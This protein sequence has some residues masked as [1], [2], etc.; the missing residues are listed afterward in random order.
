VRVGDHALQVVVGPTA[1]QVAGQMRDRL[2]HPAPSSGRRD[3]LVA[4][5]REALGGAVNV[6][7]IESCPG[8]LLVAVNDES[9]IDEAALRKLGVRAIAR[10]SPG[11]LHLLHPDA[12]F[13][14]T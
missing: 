12:E 9:R 14:G 11:V 2:A 1:D 8:R 13:V 6:S 5:V 4:G 10:P 7:S 3:A